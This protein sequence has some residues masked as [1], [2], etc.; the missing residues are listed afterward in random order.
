MFIKNFKVKGTDVND[1]MV[2]ENTAFLRYSSKIIEIFL[3]EN[4]Y[5]KLKLNTQKIGWQNRNDSLTNK[6]RLMFTET[7]SAQL[8]IDNISTSENYKSI[9]VIDFYNNKNELSATLTTELFWFDYATWQ[10]IS[11][12]KRISNFFVESKQ[13]REAV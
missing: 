1:F 4:G 5:S 10:P 2:M 8:L 7:F 6:K 11:T 3:M 13:M 9:V 12:P